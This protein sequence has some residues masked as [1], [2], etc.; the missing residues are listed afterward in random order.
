ML[1]HK[2]TVT[3]VTQRLTLRRFVPDDAPTMFRNWASDDNVTRYLTWF[4]HRSV[5]ETADIVNR[6]VAEYEADN[7]YQWAIVLRELG[8]P[9]GSIG[10]VRQNEDAAAAELGYCIGEAFWHRG[11]VSEALR[12]VMDF[13]FDEVGY[14]RLSAIHDIRNPR[15]GAVMKACGM[16]YEGTR[17]EFAL[18]KEGDL[19]SV[20]E[21]ALLRRERHTKK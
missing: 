13:L 20:A 21:Y 19:L 9:I 11:Y 18:T 16:Q 6:W 15:S 5:E 2:G 14:N 1:T 17:R 12:A 10:V 4:A 7:R 8:E 3:I